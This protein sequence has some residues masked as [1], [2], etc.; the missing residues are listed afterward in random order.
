M[1][2]FLG[3]VILSITSGFMAKSIPVAFLVLGVGLV[4]AGIV[5][6]L[7]GEPRW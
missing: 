5:E 4:I 6:Y 1:L 7:D 3:L 2:Y